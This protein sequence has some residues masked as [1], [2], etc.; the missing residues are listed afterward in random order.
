MKNFFIVLSLFVFS[1]TYSQTGTWSHVSVLPNTNPSINSI[2]VVDANTIWVAASASTTSNVYLSTNGGTNWT[3]KNGGIETAKSMYGMFAFD[4]TTA[5]VGSE[6]GDIYKTTNGGTNWTKVLDL[7]GSFSDGIYMFN[8]NYGI[9]YGDPTATSGQPY[10]IRVTTNGGNNWTLVPNAPVSSTEYG[11]IN[12]W[13]CTDSNHVWFGSANITASSTSAKV[14]RTTNGF[15]GNWL[16]ISVP[17]LGGTSGCYYQAVAFVNNTDG[18]IGSSGGD[19]K[20]TTDGGATYSAVTVPGALTGSFAVITMNSIKGSNNTI[21]MATQGDTTRLFKT[22]NL[23]ITWIRESIPS[24]ATA[25]N[26]QIQHIQ[27]L[28]PNLGFAALGGSSGNGGLLKYMGT[29]GINSNTGIIP[30]NYKLEQNFPN[31]FNP[32]TTI[33]FA[34]PKDGFVSLKMYDALGREVET[35]VSEN[36]SAGIQEVTYDASKLNSGIY[37]YRI[38]TN[39]F[40]DTKKMVL[41]K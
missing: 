8:T 6:D 22:T 10:Q 17:G 18:M 27:F 13:D 19:I 9:Y 1:I 14:Y 15:F 31:P 20:K 40:T 2:Y 5:L 29:N 39:G 21:R 32:S 16:S 33:R 23:G 12:A 11:V 34:L 36:L 37:F 7:T 35:L 26:E 38:Y 41:V 24:Q 25:T 3:L 4:A 28:N 30:S